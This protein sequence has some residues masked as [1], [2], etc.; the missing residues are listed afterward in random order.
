[1]DDLASIQTALWEGRSK[2]YD[3]GLQ[4]G[5]TPGT[6]DAIQRTNHHVADDCFRETLK[7]WLSSPNLKPSLNRLADALKARPVGLEQLAEELSKL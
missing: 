5:L 1:M 7:E 4:L 2:W 6:L 3:I